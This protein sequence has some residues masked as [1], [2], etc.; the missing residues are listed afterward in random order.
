M[1][2]LVEGVAKI[3]GFLESA[4]RGIGRIG[5]QSLNYIYRGLSTGTLVERRSFYSAET[6]VNA[7]RTVWSI[8]STPIGWAVI[9]GGSFALGI[10]EQV[11]KIL[12]EFY[13][14]LV[15]E[16]I[17]VLLIQPETNKGCGSR[18]QV[19]SFLGMIL[20]YISL[21]VLYWFY[22][23]YRITKYVIKNLPAIILFVFLCFVF[24][25][26]MQRHLQ[27]A[28]D[29]VQSS[30]RGLQSGAN[31][32]ISAMN[33]AIRAQTTVAP[34]TNYQVRTGGIT[35]V[36]LY[37]AFSGDQLG[38][39]PSY[40]QN[41]YPADDP[42]I[43]RRRLSGD[44][45][46][47]QTKDKVD[48]MLALGLKI[49]EIFFVMFE[50]IL[51]IAVDLGIVTILE[52]L[53]NV[54]DILA[55]KLVCMFAGKY[56]TILELAD[57]ILNNF[58][59][60]LIR[61]IV[62]AIAVLVTGHEIDFRVDVSCGTAM[63]REL[64]VSS[65]C[66][67]GVITTDPKGFF[68]HAPPADSRRLLS[69]SCEMI[70]YGVYQETVNENVQSQTYHRNDS[71]PLTKR[72]L[73]AF[74]NAVNLEMFD[75]HDCYHVKVDGVLVDVCPD[76]SKKILGSYKEEKEFEF[77]AAV[78]HL[79]RM[80]DTALLPHDFE[81]KIKQETEQKNQVIERFDELPILK[82]RVLSKY[83]KIKKTK[84]DI[85][86]EFTLRDGTRC[87]LTRSGSFTDILDIFEQ[88]LCI[89]M[90]YLET[91]YSNFFTATE[92]EKMVQE[93]FKSDIYN[94]GGFSFDGTQAKPAGRNLL[95]AFSAKLQ[96]RK[97]KLSH[98]GHLSPIDRVAVMFGVTPLE[99]DQD[100]QN[101]LKN[102]ERM[103]KRQE[104]QQQT[105]RR[106]LGDIAWG[107]EDHRQDVIARR[108]LFIE[109]CRDQEVKCEGIE[110]L[111][112]VK[113]V[114]FCPNV[115]NMRYLQLASYYL[116]LGSKRLDDMDFNDLIYDTALCFKELKQFPEFDCSSLQNIGKTD[117]ATLSQ[118]LYCPGM[119]RAYDYEIP[120]VQWS[121]QS[122][123]ADS[124]TSNTDF[125][126]CACPDYYSLSKDVQV[127]EFRFA[128]QDVWYTFLNSLLWVRYL[129]ARLG[130]GW[131][132]VSS[133]VGEVC[134]KEVCTSTVSNIFV[135][136][137][138]GNLSQKELD[139][140][141]L[142]NISSVGVVGL[143]LYMFFIPMVDAF[144]LYVH[145]WFDITVNLLLARKGAQP[146]RT[147][148]S[149]IKEHF[150]DLEQA[151]A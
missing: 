21:N 20:S 48:K 17:K 108:N 76:G 84:F 22:L 4:F 15:M 71:C 52:G 72:S 80:L 68:Q 86:D 87:K 16:L 116:D 130:F 43:V 97:R 27:D 148:D 82:G 70:G 61:L 24:V 135:G 126:T 39:K 106:M 8:F 55:V 5:A 2:F 142:I 75:H 151:A 36:D 141:W 32:A 60:G 112:C 81:S 90:Y 143:F 58:V 91:R 9:V 19:Y 40:N 42:L 65:Q 57:F 94:Y 109:T 33:G 89:G 102:R 98:S 44:L 134:A 121:L 136:S 140:C 101:Y 62:N 64:K 73:H 85:P 49:N 133:V 23:L 69:V 41:L 78:N 37:E 103:F 114:S 129:F 59:L 119:Y 47:Q 128:S 6:K 79:N 131:A 25:Y 107:S 146:K 115:K 66:L 46:N 150:K 12:G 28:L 138:N 88:G 132:E 93:Q 10:L 99:Y 34:Y 118:C 105:T 111:L 122:G 145:F 53:A 110:P 63:L 18:F 29:L 1:S 127:D 14:F 50:T 7:G 100:I 149:F 35:A 54:I 31:A 113:D 30:S 96:H 38:A 45:Y 139:A 95:T 26:L 56:C 144:R 51:E 83:I 3:P 125:N 77:D 123:L 104:Q 137:N 147:P 117:Q 67:G 13:R 74:G 92:F 120:K 11:V 124:C